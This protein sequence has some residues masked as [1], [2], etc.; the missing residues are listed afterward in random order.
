LLN[1]GIGRKLDDLM[2]RWLRSREPRLGP[3]ETELLHALRRRGHATVRELME[4]TASAGAY[5][6]LMT[7]LDRLYKKGLVERSLEGRAFRYRTKET[8]EEYTRTTIQANLQ[9]LLDSASDP[10][11]PLSFLVDTVSEHDAALLDEL[12]R[13]VDRKKQSLRKREAR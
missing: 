10:T 3:L 4:D 12:A 2:L 6:T 5:T 1:S 8:E 11:A 9:R 13:A 7:T